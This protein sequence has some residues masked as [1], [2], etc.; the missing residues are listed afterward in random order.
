MRRCLLASLLM[1]TVLHAAPVVPDLTGPNF[2][3]DQNTQ[4]TVISGGARLVYGPTVLTADEIRYNRVTA[5]A[6]AIGHVVL[7]HGPQ[8]VLADRLSYRLSDGFFQV[9]HARLGEYP[10]YVSADSAAGTKSQ[11]TFRDAT[12]TLREPDP[13]A[14]TLHADTLVYEPGKRLSADHADLGIGPVR[15]IALPHFEQ[16]LDEPLLSYVDFT[17]G[18][19]SLL[20][21]YVG[22]GL[23][24]PVTPDVKLGGDVTFYSRRG[25]FLGP[26]GTYDHVDADQ[27]VNGYFRSGFISDHGERGTDVLGRSVPADRGYF[28]WQH[29][30]TIDS[31]VTVTADVNYWSDSEILRDFQPREFYPLEAPDN[32]IEA[33]YAGENYVVSA[34]TRFH[35]NNF[36]LV[37]ERLPEIRFDLLPL[38]VGG[39]F[40]ERA[41]ASVAVLRED[42]LLTGPT[43]HSNRY[44]AFYELARPVAPTNWFTF[45][46]VAG[47]RLT[48]YA[49]ALDGKDTYTRTLGEAGFDSELRSSGTW[50]YK[51]ER[52]HIDG[53]RHLFTPQISYR[54][55]PQA[56]KGQPYI[57]AIDADTFSPYLQPLD[58]GDMRNVDQLHR[59][60]TLRLALDNILQTRDPQ[61]GSRNLLHLNIADDLRLSR[62]PGDKALSQVQTELNATPVNW[63]Q[64]DTLEIFSPQQGQHRELGTGLTIRD[65]GQRSFSFFN[66]FLRGQLEDYGFEYHEQITE[67][68]EVVERLTYDAHVRRFDQQVVDLVQNLRNTWRVHYEIALLNGD[69]HEGHLGLNL[70]IE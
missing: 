36:Y 13:F 37:Q 18:Y 2:G 30:Q 14:P 61:Y 20:G 1:A 46:P 25:F 51:N 4:E 31:H 28:E 22:A 64:L 57:P 45:T 70:E 47:G 43:Q 24:V 8:R 54:Y 23:H 67:A 49:R 59:T 52:W 53:L 15:P 66:H 6:T 62:N 58:L 33:D 63:L 26:S 40:Y 50:D 5:T 34:L 10:V 29:L 7:T 35:P 39:G 27:D 12:V 32:F 44:D 38:A 16:H 55:I 56:A 3:Y 42:A 65:G 41:S 19:R 9:E 48:Y 68:F 11:I 60:N 21:G 69:R 17:G